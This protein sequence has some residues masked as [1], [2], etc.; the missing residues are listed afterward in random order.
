MTTGVVV[1][2]FRPPH[3][4]H[5][6]LIDTAAA[7]VDRLWVLVI[8]SSAHEA[9]LPVTQRAAWIREIHR[10]PTI[11]VIATVIDHPVSHTDPDVIDFWNRTILRLTGQERIDRLFTSEAHT[12][13]EVTAAGIGAEHVLV[14]PRRS[15][16]PIAGHQVMGHPVAHL[17][18]LEPP[19]RA[20]FVPRIRIVGG[21]STGKTT[22][23]DALARRLSTV[24]VPEH[25]RT[26]STPKDRLGEPWT[27]EDFMVIARRQ[28]A[29]EDVMARRA[30]G[31]LVCDTDAMTTA[32]WHTVYL[33]TTFAPL[34]ALADARRHYAVTLLG[35]T[36]IP[37]TQDGDR[38][39]YEE[40]ARQQA[41]LVERM[42]GRGEHWVR[43]SGTVR[44]RVH[45][46]LEAVSPVV[47]RIPD[48]AGW[49]DLAEQYRWRYLE[50]RPDAK[51]RSL[52]IRGSGLRAGTA[53]D[54]LDQLATD[55][56]GAS[57][58]LGIE[59]DALLEADW[60]AAMHDE[61]LDA[62]RRGNLEATERLAQRPGAS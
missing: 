52:G 31:A 6:L 41:E 46:S 58:V 8:G 21:E 17:A 37:W 26:Y 28:A 39:S 11:E 20:H 3:R 23:A 61:L 42:G 30:L 10:Q 50:S 18:M 2:K 27:S 56:A 47:A 1:G 40:R 54:L 45:A 32:M 36:D 9:E 35:D 60:Y 14:D 34:E 43:V 13:G 51:L 7:G 16:F 5:R 48:D 19:V 22:L 53:R 55:H 62:E 59:P 25:G 24:W 29:L 49:L 4:G 44:E 12:Y 15:A 38:H 57:A 33:G